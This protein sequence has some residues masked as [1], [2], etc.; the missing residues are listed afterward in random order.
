[1]TNL[2]SKIAVLLTAAVALSSC[3]S[4][5]N[6]STQ[7]IP[8]TSTPTGANVSVD[9]QLAG[10]TPTRVNVK[11]KRSHIVTVSKVGYEPEHVYLSREISPAVAGN[12]FIPGGLI[13]WGVDAA[14]GAQYKMVPDAV[15]V[16]L[17]PTR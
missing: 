3:A 5:L 7:K 11:R 1:M 15:N 6:G 8:V 13:G 10:L 4:V 2:F 12:L 16:H 17:T 9:G 14:S